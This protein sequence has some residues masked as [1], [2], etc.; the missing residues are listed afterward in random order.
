MTHYPLFWVCLAPLSFLSDV[1]PIAS[2]LSSSLSSA[3]LYSSF[4]L[5][6]V[7]FSVCHSAGIRKLK[8]ENELTAQL[9]R[10]HWEDIQMSNMEKV[11]RRTCS[12]LTMSLVRGNTLSFPIVSSSLSKYTVLMFIPLYTHREALTMAHC[13]QW[14]ETSRSMPRLATTRY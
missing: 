11:L 6:S 2:D 4:F 13:W 10:V 12:K 7:F 9:W 14:M 1:S 8:L 5:S 3:Y